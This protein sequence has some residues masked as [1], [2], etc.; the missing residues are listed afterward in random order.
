MENRDFGLRVFWKEGESDTRK[1]GIFQKCKNP[2]LVNCHVIAECQRAFEVFNFN[3]F[4]SK[5]SNEHDW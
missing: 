5:L 2:G 3:L 4:I 1:R